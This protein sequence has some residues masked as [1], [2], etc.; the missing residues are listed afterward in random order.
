M[1]TDEHRGRHAFAGAETG[2]RP[3]AVRADPA[4]NVLPQI[5][6][7]PCPSVVQ[8]RAASTNRDRLEAAAVAR[9]DLGGGETGFDRASRGGAEPLT[10]GGCLGEPHLPLGGMSDARIRPRLP[11]RIGPGVA[12]EG[13]QPRADGAAVGFIDKF[14]GCRPVGADDRLAEVHALGDCEAETLASMKRYKHI[15]RRLEPVQ[16]GP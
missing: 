12:I 9:A 11:P 5:R 3:G 2:P 16:V 13:D 8:N 6:V 4:G 10:Q 7:Y 14:S 1:E 15:A